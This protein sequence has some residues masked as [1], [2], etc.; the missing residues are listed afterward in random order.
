MTPPARCCA[1]SA[2]GNHLGGGP[3]AA[4]LDRT[5][6][7]AASLIHR[8][9]ER[10]CA[11]A[12]RAGAVAGRSRGHPV[13]TDV[14]QA[15][16]PHHRR[17]DR[18][19]K[20]LR[21]AAVSNYDDANAYLQEHYIAQHNRHYARPAAGTVHTLHP[22][23]GLRRTVRQR[24]TARQLDDVFWL[25]EERVLSEDWVVR[26]KNRLLQLAR[27]NRHWAPAQSR[28]RVRENEPGHIVIHYR[29]QSLPCREI[30]VAS[31]TAKSR[32][33]GADP[34]PA[35]Q[36]PTPTAAAGR[37][38]RSPAGNHPW[39]QGWQNMKTPAFSPAW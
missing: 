38:H 24:P 34:S 14:R 29:G 1:S 15:G 18:L 27:Q 11:P 6:R 10:V 32:G 7:R 36:S 12:Q 9:E 26:Y 5:L 37:P 17:Q 20:K 35:T 23:L 8:L 33:R 2:R 22:P 4:C 21:L 39:R 25:E 31:S 19:V 30:P 3:S 28:V 16:D 13:R